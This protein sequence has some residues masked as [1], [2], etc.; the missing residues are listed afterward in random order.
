MTVSAGNPQL[1]PACPI[2][3][4]GRRAKHTAGDVGWEGNGAARVLTTGLWGAKL[5]QEGAAGPGG[6]D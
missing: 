3:G 5:Q 6:H 2:T 4:G 1:T